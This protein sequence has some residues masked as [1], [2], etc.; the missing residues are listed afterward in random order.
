MSSVLHQPVSSLPTLPGPRGLPLVGSVPSLLRMGVFEFLEQCWRQYG[1]IFQIA[2]GGRSRLI[3][4]SHPDAVERILQGSVDN[5][6]KGRSYDPIRPLVGNGLV[7]STGDFW[8]RQRKLTQ[9]VFNRNGLRRLLPAMTR[10]VH[11]MLGAWEAHRVAGTTLDIHAE[12]NALAQRIIGF[13]LFGL[14]LSGAAAATAQAVADSLHIAGERVNRGALVIPLGVPTP[15]N[16]RYKRALRTLDSVVYDIIA[17]ARRRSAEDQDV[18]LLRML[19]DARDPDTGEAMNDKQLRDEII[20]HFVAGHETTAL[21]LT[22][23]FYLLDRHPEVVT[24]MAEEVATVCAT[25]TPSFEQLEQLTYTRM[26][27]DEVMRLRPPVWAQ[28]R[29]T[30][31]DDTLLGYPIPADS[32][33]LFSSYFCHRHPAF[34][35]D[36]EAF[37]AERF[38]PEAVKQRHRY[39]HF[40]FSAG[41]RACI[42]KRLGLYELT[43][44]LA[45]ILPRFRVELL[46]GQTV[47]MKV[48]GT[49]HPDRPIMVRLT[50]APPSAHASS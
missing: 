48:G 44:V 40:P 46:P 43:L 42:G 41:P 12:M 7:T 37:R 18:T 30:H 5:Y 49:C 38:A 50:A 16:L 27:L 14:D 17:A 8:V 11:D 15:S 47:G 2:T 9:P 45:L 23:T 13:T 26:V 35:D 39:A 34:W 19:M 36:P 28:T 1:E 33:V 10:C 22:W 24:R 21:V 29:V 32:I 6:Y 31:Q 3:V 20:T 4:V 25:D